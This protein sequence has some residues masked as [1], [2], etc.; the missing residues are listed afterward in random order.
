MVNWLKKVDNIKTTDTSGLV[1]NADYD[2]K[3]GEYEKKIPD[4]GKLK[5][6]IS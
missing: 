4:H 5:N 6:L 2:T 1:K 3:I